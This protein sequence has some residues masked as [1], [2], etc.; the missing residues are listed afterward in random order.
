M[1]T[2]IELLKEW[3]SGIERGAQARFAQ[4]MK[5]SQSAIT[6]WMSGAQIPSEENI[7]KMSKLFKKSEEEIKEIFGVNKKYSVRASDVQ[8]DITLPKLG[9][10]MKNEVVLVDLEDMPNK[11]A[12]LMRK[13]VIIEVRDSS[14][15]G[16]YKPG[17]KLKVILT[18]IIGNATPK[19][20]FVE[21]RD[22]ELKITK[23]LKAD[24]KLLGYVFAYERQEAEIVD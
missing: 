22:K 13:K 2:F 8:E 18:D 4:D 23:T 1:K 20:Y 10:L 12:F 6:R 3:N 24:S 5:L 9:I 21:N 16:D 14:L 7:K 15:T 19:Y 11:E 17:D